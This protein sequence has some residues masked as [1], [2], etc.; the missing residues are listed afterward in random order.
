MQVNDQGL[1]PCIRCGNT[2]PVLTVMPP[3]VACTQC[4]NATVGQL[5]DVSAAQAAWNRG[6][7]SAVM[8][9]R[10]PQ[11]VLDRLPTTSPEHVAAVAVVAAADFTDSAPGADTSAG[12]ASE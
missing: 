4:P 11:H 2:N 8:T 12:S 10:I 6:N 3:G 5:F 7:D 9:R 1:V